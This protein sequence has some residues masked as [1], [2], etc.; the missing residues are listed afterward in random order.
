MKTLRKFTFILLLNVCVFAMHANETANVKT[1]LLYD[2]NS[3][4]NIGAEFGIASRW[5]LDLS[6][7]YNPW[8]LSD[9]M[10]IR[11]WLAQPE[12]RWWT[13]NRFEGHFLAIHAVGGEYNLNKA[14]LLYNIY[15]ELRDHR[16][17]G[18]GAG[19]GIAYGYRWSF[20]SRWAMEGEI[21]VGAIYSKFNRYACGSCGERLGSGSKTY[22]GPT[23]LALNLIYRFGAKENKQ[24]TVEPLLLEEKKVTNAIS[25]VRPD[26]VFIERI[27]RDTVFKN[28]HDTVFDRQRIIKAEFALRLNYHLDSDVIDPML[29]HNAEQIDSLSL[30]IKRYSDNPAIRIRSI[31]IVGYSSIEGEAQANQQLSERR[32]DAAAQLVADMRPDLKPLIHAYGMGEDWESIDFLGKESLMRESDLNIR[33]RK[34]RNIDEGRLMRSLLTTRLPQTRRIECVIN[35]TKIENQNN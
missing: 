14:Q 31:D 30:F 1:N 27:V 25:T 20:N 9:G 33:E 4:I 35:F 34:L 32:A 17:Q 19:G 29:G 12:L 18:W 26:T 2:L 6:G 3:T 22:V 24:K 28:L 5:S 11:H 16:F 8:T 7:S 21:G 10:K 15:P 23:K 13:R